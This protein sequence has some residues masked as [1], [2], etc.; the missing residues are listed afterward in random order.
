MVARGNAQNVTPF[1]AGRY[2]WREMQP[3]GRE[4]HRRRREMP[5]QR[6]NHTVSGFRGVAVYLLDEGVAA[7]ALN[8]RNVWIEHTAVLERRLPVVAYSGE[9]RPCIPVESG[10]P[11]RLNP[12][13]YSGPIRPPFG[14]NPARVLASSV[15]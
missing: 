1:G 10:H 7:I 11:F 9:I 5:T 8:D 4:T 6:G 15:Q 12:A 3:T 14:R 13:T 2:A